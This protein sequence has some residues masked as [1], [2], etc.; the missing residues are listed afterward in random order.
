MDYPAPCFGNSTLPASMASTDK[1][2]PP[3]AHGFQDALSKG[4]VALWELTTTQH[5]CWIL[6]TGLLVIYD[7]A[8]CSYSTPSAH[9][10]LPLAPCG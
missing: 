2:K 8:P 5:S 10:L 3:V 6:A 4:C 1:P 9:P 7:C